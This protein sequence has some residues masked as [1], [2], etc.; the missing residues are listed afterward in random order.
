M[1]SYNKQVTYNKQVLNETM[2]NI[3]IYTP[4]TKK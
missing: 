2:Q 1:L 3:S 4:K